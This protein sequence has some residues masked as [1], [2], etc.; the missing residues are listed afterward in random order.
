MVMSVRVRVVVVKFLWDVGY[1]RQMVLQRRQGG[2]SAAQAH[3][4][5]ARH[6]HRWMQRTGQR[7]VRAILPSPVQYRGHAGH[8]RW[9]PVRWH[10]V[11]VCRR[12]S[13][14]WRVHQ[15]PR[16]MGVWHAVQIPN[17]F[18]CKFHCWKT[19]FS[20]PSLP[21]SLTLSLPINFKR[22]QSRAPLIPEIFSVSQSSI[23]PRT[24]T[25][26]CI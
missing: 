19:V 26:A 24:C 14:V 2:V 3:A 25:Y 8:H 7:M 9:P 23:S 15:V 5:I 13:R 17:V 16:L 22:S 6:G 4:R 18:H 11:P 12:L 20:S 10:Q 21:F 1:G